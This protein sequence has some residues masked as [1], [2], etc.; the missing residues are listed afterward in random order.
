MRLPEVAGN[1]CRSVHC[2]SGKPLSLHRCKWRCISIPKRLE[3]AGPVPPY[4]SV[5]LLPW[6]WTGRHLRIRHWSVRVKEPWCQGQWWAGCRVRKLRFRGA[7]RARHISVRD[8]SPAVSRFLLFSA[9]RLLFCSVPVRKIAVPHW[10][11][12]NILQ[13]DK[14]I[15][16]RCWCNRPG[17]LLR[18]S[19]Q[20]F[21][22]RVH[23]PCFRF[24][25]WKPEWF[26]LPR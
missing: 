3:W 25:W 20:V 17:K 16:A 22:W 24:S 6:K 26:L 12:N 13:A 2:I 21:R 8:C 7:A 9:Q 1:G 19:G 11:V 18:P 23:P 5:W 4:G 14:H 15:S 10:E